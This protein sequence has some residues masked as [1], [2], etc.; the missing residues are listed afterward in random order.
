MPSQRFGWRFRLTRT[1][2]ILGDW[3]I[4]SW[5]AVTGPACSTVSPISLPPIHSTM[6][7]PARTWNHPLAAI[8]DEALSSLFPTVS[9]YHGSNNNCADYPNLRNPNALSLGFIIHFNLTRMQLTTR[10]SYILDCVS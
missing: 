6:E 4:H 1:R 8:P 2:V 9:T 7:T 10:M 3:F 5:E